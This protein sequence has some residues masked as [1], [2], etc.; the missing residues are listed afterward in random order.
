MKPRKTPKK[1][2]KMAA[3][4]AALKAVKEDP[5]YE[6]VRS[7]GFYESIPDALNRCNDILNSRTVERWHRIRFFGSARP[8]GFV[9]HKDLEVNASTDD[10][11]TMLAKLIS[12]EGDWWSATVE[13]IGT[14]TDE[15]GL[16]QAV[17]MEA[18]ARR[19]IQKM[20]KWD[21]V[22]LKE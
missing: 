16:V 11:E 15:R 9:D 22:Q 7:R 10:I 3:V 2:A 18:K 19:I 1:K 20:E 14:I 21:D 6:R 12:T 4:E 13:T 17:N 8:I 5:A